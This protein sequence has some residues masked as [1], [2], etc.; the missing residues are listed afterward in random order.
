MMNCF[1][2]VWYTIRSYS[3]ITTIE[4]AWNEHGTD[5]KRG[6]LI[7]ERRL[8]LNKVDDAKHAN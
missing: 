7:A 2:T 8:D 1:T 6:R 5:L 3:R 4:S